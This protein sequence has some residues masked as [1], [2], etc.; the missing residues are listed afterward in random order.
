MNTTC[1]HCEGKG[2][3]EIRDCSGEI[4]REETCLFCG[5]TGKLKIEDE[6]D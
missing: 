3:I 2:Y 5:G 4:Q 6:E 1:P